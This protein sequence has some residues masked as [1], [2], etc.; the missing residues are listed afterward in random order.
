[1]SLRRQVA[2]LE[3]RVGELELEAVHLRRAATRASA[4]APANHHRDPLSAAI[5][6][7]HASVALQMADTATEPES[8]N[9]TPATGSPSIR[10][11]K[12]VDPQGSALLEVQHQY[13]QLKMMHKALE[14]KMWLGIRSP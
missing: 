9:T 12:I 5:V 3:E 6:P 4:A 2:I 8:P 10:R 14:E 13:E 11:A 7:S 1:M